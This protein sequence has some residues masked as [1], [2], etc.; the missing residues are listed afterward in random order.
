MTLTEKT[1]HIRIYGSLRD[2]VSNGDIN[3]RC[4][5]ETTIKQILESLTRTQIHLPPLELLKRQT[6]VVLNGNV[7][8]VISP[9]RPGDTLSLF[10]PLSG[11]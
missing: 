11:G 9:V 10:P 3:I 4:E 2:K 1:I 7:A 8:N 6:V 5:Q